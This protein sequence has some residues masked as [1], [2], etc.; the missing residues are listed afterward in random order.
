V[1]HGE[2]AALVIVLY[3]QREEEAIERDGKRSTDERKR[4]GPAAN[5]ISIM[6]QRYVV[7]PL[8]V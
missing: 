2:W 1:V 6:V 3:S 5:M 7:A 8:S 4:D